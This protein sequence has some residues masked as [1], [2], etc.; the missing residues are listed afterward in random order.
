[1]CG[2]SERGAY[3]A[4]AAACVVP[5]AALGAPAASQRTPPEAGGRAKDTFDAPPPPSL[6]Y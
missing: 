5:A 6:A 4:P 1:M 2:W 3:G